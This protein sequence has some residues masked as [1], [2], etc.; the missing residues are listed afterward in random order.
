VSENRSHE[1][2][3]EERKS[4]R[5]GESSFSRKRITLIELWR[6]GEAAERRTRTRHG[7]RHEKNANTIKER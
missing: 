3:N 1:S 6:A 4:K 7:L 2:P 5:E